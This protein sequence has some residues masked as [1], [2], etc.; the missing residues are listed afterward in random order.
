MRDDLLDAIVLERLNVLLR[1]HLEEVLVAQTP[2]RIA[3]TGLLLPQNG[4]TH[5]GLLQDFHEGFGDLD[6]AVY[7]GTSA[8]DPEKILGLRMI[9]QQWHLEALGP[10]S[11]CGLCATPGVPTLLQAAQRRFSSF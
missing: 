1:Q 9:G 7:Q 10:A 5:P 3:G 8:P 4:K 6:V 2:G 11:A